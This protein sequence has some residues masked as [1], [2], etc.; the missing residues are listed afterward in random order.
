MPDLGRVIGT[1]WATRKVEKSEGAKIQLVQPLDGNLKKAGKPFAAVDTVGAGQ[2]E[3][4]YYTK[5]Y[6]AVIAYGVPLV[7][8]DRAI[9]GIV[10]SIYINKE[11]YK[12]ATM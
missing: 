9:I 11:I 12:D 1:I 2:G 7:P 10:D 8:W 4:V 6:E 5:A 3:I